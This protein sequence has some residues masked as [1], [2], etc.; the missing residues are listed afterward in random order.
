[1][2]SA[3]AIVIVVAFFGTV[4]RQETILVLN[5]CSQSW[6]SILVLN[7]CSQGIKFHIFVTKPV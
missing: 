6:F 5:P 2:A 4:Y 3:S 7:P 1:M